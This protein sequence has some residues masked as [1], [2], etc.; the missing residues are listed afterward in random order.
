MNISQI[1]FWKYWFL[2]CTFIIFTQLPV[3]YFQFHVFICFSKLTEFHQTWWLSAYFLL[4]F[5]VYGEARRDSKG[6]QVRRS[7]S[8][9]K[10][11]QTENLLAKSASI[12]PRTSLSHLANISNK[13]R[14]E[15]CTF[16]SNNACFLAQVEAH[17]FSIMLDSVDQ[18]SFCWAFLRFFILSHWDRAFTA[19]VS[20][21]TASTLSLMEG[22][23]YSRESVSQRILLAAIQRVDRHTCCL[24]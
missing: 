16:A 2:N 20:S 24:T 10:M 6:A 12:Q 9:W 1:S 17:R 23:T 11:L 15:R 14:S 3:W 7:C 13:N 19:I 22:C 4:I 21:A 8:A 18:L 5:G